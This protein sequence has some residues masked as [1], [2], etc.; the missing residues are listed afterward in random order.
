MKYIFV[1]LYYIFH[2]TYCI[3]LNF[4]QKQLINKI[5]QNPQITPYQKKFIHN[6]LYKSYE[7]LAI[8]KAREFKNLHYYKCQNIYEDELVLYAKFGLWKSIINFKG[9]VP[10]EKYCDIYIK[11]ELNECLNDKYSLSILP[12]SFRSKSKQ[13]MTDIER[14]NYNSL[15]TVIT[16]EEEWWFQHTDFKM[17]N[18]LLNEYFKDKWEF[19]NSTMDTSIKFILYLK[20][21]FY[22]NKRMSNKQISD[23]INLSEEYV[24]L[25]NKHFLKSMKEYL[26]IKHDEM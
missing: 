1:I 14:K 9:Y 4:T 18:I 5:L 10:L 11:H 3:H 2:V 12:K 7:K 22:F 24:R 16:T 25:K 26:D 8:R 17:D 20:Y 6:T 19:I 23:I 21:D 15:L 13:N